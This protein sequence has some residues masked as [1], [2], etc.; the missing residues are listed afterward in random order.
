EDEFAF[1]SFLD[2]RKQDDSGRRENLVFGA[3]VAANLVGLEALKEL[4]GVLPAKSVGKIIVLDLLELTTT[5]HL[6]LRKPWCPACFKTVPENE[7]REAAPQVGTG[8]PA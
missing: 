3:N 6:V 5:K 1:E 7:G 8:E 4:S 2:R